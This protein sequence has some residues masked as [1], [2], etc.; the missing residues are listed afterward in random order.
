MAFLIII[1]AFAITSFI[2]LFFNSIV[3]FLPPNAFFK[4]QFVMNTKQR[5]RMRKSDD[6]TRALSCRR[7]VQIFCL[8]RTVTIPVHADAERVLLARLPLSGF[9]GSLSDAPGLV[10]SLSGVFI[11]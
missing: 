10:L 2:F 11:F 5:R 4:P 8:K 9:V 6:G 1:L 3:F 7:T